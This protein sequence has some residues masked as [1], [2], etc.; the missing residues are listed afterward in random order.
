MTRMFLHSYNK[1]IKKDI[2]YIFKFLVLAEISRINERKNRKMLDDVLLVIE[3]ISEETGYDIISTYCPYG[4]TNW[5]KFEI[6]IL[7]RMSS[8]EISEIVFLLTFLNVIKMR[9]KK[10][11]RDRSFLDKIIHTMKSGFTE[12]N[13]FLGNTE[14]E[15]AYKDCENK[16]KV[17]VKDLF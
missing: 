1:M 13:S 16:A 15:G 8:I 17:I 9:A 10:R 7:K 2:Y 14:L 12:Y 11:I 5:D 4:L 6:Y 3:I